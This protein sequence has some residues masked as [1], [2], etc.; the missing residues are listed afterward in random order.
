M[1]MKVPLIWAAPLQTCDNTD[2]TRHKLVK[3]H[4]SQMLDVQ[5]IRSSDFL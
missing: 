2:N 1:V 4:N 5:M 3:I